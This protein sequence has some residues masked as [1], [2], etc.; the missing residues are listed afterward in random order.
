M[1]NIRVEL[2]RNVPSLFKHQASN[3][4]PFTNEVQMVPYYKKSS[5]TSPYQLLI[6]VPSLIGHHSDHSSLAHSKIV[7]QV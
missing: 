3:K 6:S 1:K 2:V 5:F 4:R 7:R